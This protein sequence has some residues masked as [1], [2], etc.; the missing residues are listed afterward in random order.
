MAVWMPVQHFFEKLGLYKCD[1]HIQ[2]GRKK[3]LVE[4]SKECAANVAK[5][6]IDKQSQAGAK[7]VNISFAR[8]S[9]QLSCYTL[10]LK[11]TAGVPNPGPQL[12]TGLQPV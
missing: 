8:P 12:T 11:S 4:I 10:L 2:V 3:E 5:A 7:G 9:P 6:I 1:C